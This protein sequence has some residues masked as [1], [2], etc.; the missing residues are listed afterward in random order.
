[1]FTGVMLILNIAGTIVGS[2]QTHLIINTNNTDSLQTAVDIFTVIGIIAAILFS[3]Y[4]L[5]KGN[6]DG[7][8]IQEFQSKS[9]KAQ[10]DLV[11]TQERLS[12]FQRLIEVYDMNNTFKQREARKNIYTAYRT[13]R[14]IHYKDGINVDGKIYDPKNLVQYKDKKFEDV[15]R[16]TAVLAELK[17]T[18]SKL[19]QDVER[20]RATFDHIGALFESSLIPEEPLLRALWGTGR[21][22][23]LCL[24]DNIMIERDKR[25]TEYYMD[26]FK[27]FF[28]KIEAYRKE[29]NLPAVDIF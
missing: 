23:W 28:N 13:Y 17:M 12:K 6:K 4:T 24:E 2:N 22:C 29:R 21:V 8:Q 14:K 25:K 16:D 15:F 3:L 18:E 20:V 10:I 27:L 5:N 9:I 1:M 26:N 7:K 11:E 19:Q